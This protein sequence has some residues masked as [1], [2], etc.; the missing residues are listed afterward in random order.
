MGRSF[1][2]ALLLASCS[3]FVVSPASAETLRMAYG[4]APVS[5]DPY[6]YSDTQTGSL[7]EHVFEMLVGLDDAPL[8]ATEWEWD[9]PTSMVFKLREGVNFSNGA[10]FVA[11]DVVYSMCRMMY[12][13]DGRANVVTSA[14]GPVTNV[15][16]VDDH[17]VRFETTAPYPIITQ[18]L[19]FLKILSAEAAGVEGDITFDQDGDCGLVD[20]YPSQADFDTG[21]AAIG[22]GPYIYES[23]Q[24]TG[25]ADLV[26]NENYWG[27]LPEWDRVEIR[28]VPNNGARIAGLLAGDYDI[29]ERPSAEDLQVIER[30]ENFD[31]S[32]VP[33]LQT[34]FIVLDTS[35]DGAGGVTAA[36]GSNPL[37]DTRVR[38]ALSMAIDRN[39]IT[40]RLFAGNATPAS[41]F[42]PSYMPGAPAMPDLVTDL[43]QAKAL[44]AE[45]GYADGFALELNVPAD[46]Y[47][48]GPLVAQAI[49][50][51]WTRLGVD[52]TLR[53]EPWSVFQTRRTEG[54]MGAFMYGWGHPQGAAQLISGAFAQRNDDLGLGA[55]NFSNYNSPAFEEAMQAW[56]VEVDPARSQELVAEAMKQAVADMPGIPLYYNHELWAH[57]ADIELVGGAEGRT[58]AT[59]ARS[60]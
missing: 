54:E 27:E 59:M 5:A 51:Y 35:A 39:A 33:G 14:L 23:F 53:T 56:A 43:D 50:Q 15:V 19:K 24:S 34:M 1:V 40:E 9:S 37:A 26:R 11:R 18:K 42:A 17:T 36:D 4:T 32:T 52:V 16:A 29:V 12:R 13:V 41:Q 21:S 49:T 3:A 57:R 25:D 58:V 38:Q 6:P 46:R 45:A 22:T 47:T 8:L 2:T 28:S 60:K 10:P 20:A 48:N 44:L 55:A 31:F 7:A 30:D